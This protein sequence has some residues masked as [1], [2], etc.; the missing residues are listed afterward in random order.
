MT[1]TTEKPPPRQKGGWVVPLAQN[2]NLHMYTMSI[3]NG[4]SSSSNYQPTDARKKNIWIIRTSEKLKYE[5]DLQDK[6]LY[7][8]NQIHL[9]ISTVRYILIW[10]ETH[11]LLS[12][13]KQLLL[14]QPKVNNNTKKTIIPLTLNFITSSILACFPSETQLWKNEGATDTC[15]LI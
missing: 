12:T 1:Y 6:L 8:T 15:E 4:F 9:D 13:Y 10:L 14:F 5:I 3:M 2:K 7:N 11:W